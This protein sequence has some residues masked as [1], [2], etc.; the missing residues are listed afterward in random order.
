MPVENRNLEV[1]TRLV[2][3]YKKA[4]YVCVV[5]K[6]EEGKLSFEVDGKVFKSPSSAASHVM[7]GQAANG[8]RFWSIEGAQPVKAE[9]K[10]PTKAAWAADAAGT[11][12]KQRRPAGRRG[13]SK[14]AASEG[15]Q[16]AEREYLIDSDGRP[17]RDR[18]GQQVYAA[19]TPAGVETEAEP[20]A[21]A[22]TAAS[23]EE[24]A[25]S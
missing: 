25:V 17:V 20:E 7:G 19:E 18:D 23:D 9:S 13:A 15:P 1:G 24:G 12:P 10:A 8:W 5:G 4:Q 3:N 14:E 21:E 22:V 11:A 16:A 6:D 2:A